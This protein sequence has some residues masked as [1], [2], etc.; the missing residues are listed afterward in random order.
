M[1]YKSPFVCL[2]NSFARQRENKLCVFESLCLNSP[3]ARQRDKI[4]VSL[5][6]KTC[7]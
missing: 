5:C 7:R 4:F 1:Q 2:K 3:L 6:L